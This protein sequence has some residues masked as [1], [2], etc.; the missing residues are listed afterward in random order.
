MDEWTI[1]DLTTW[2]HRAA[3][4]LSGTGELQTHKGELTSYARR[5]NRELDLADEYVRWLHGG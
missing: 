4:F 2:A 5:I 3:S 1:R